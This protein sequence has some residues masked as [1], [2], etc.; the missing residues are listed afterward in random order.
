MGTL[1]MLPGYARGFL[2]LMILAISSIT[3]SLRSGQAS[4]TGMGW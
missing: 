4:I 1:E 3:N 2:P